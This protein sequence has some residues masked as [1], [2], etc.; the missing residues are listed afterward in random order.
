M[1]MENVRSML[2]QYEPKSSFYFADKI[3]SKKALNDV[4]ERIFSNDTGTCNKTAE[5]VD[6]VTGN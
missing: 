4:V 1:L 5:T 6:L 2:Y 3:L